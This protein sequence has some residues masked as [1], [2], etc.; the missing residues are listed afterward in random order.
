M[1]HS[2]S[3]PTAIYL[4]PIS[5]IRSFAVVSSFVNNCISIL[6]ALNG[7]H[8][9]NIRAFVT[10]EPHFLPGGKKSIRNKFS[11]LN[12]IYQIHI[13]VTHFMHNVKLHFKLVV[14]YS[15]F[16]VQ[17]GNRQS[18]LLWFSMSRGS[19][20]LNFPYNL[21]VFQA[22]F[23]QSQPPQIVRDRC[24]FIRQVSGSN[25]NSP[26]VVFLSFSRLLEYTMDTP[27]HC[28]HKYN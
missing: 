11:D 22:W 5:N 13:F 9:V 4:S 25:P 8:I 26:V 17:W 16:G 3:P 10:T 19:P 21:G 6:T 12:I 28:L 1:L 2:N 18:N 15:T 20:N 27:S 7:V 24:N 14:A 23:L